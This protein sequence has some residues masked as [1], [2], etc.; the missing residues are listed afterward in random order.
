[1]KEGRTCQECQSRRNAT[2]EFKGYGALFGKK[3]VLKNSPVDASFCLDC[4][5]ILLLK[6]R[7]TE[8]FR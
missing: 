8:K 2:G 6:V 7:N 4:G 3:S 1:M 5:T